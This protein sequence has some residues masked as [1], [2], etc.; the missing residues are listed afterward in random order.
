MLKFGLINFLE[1]PTGKSERQIT[2]EQKFILVSAEE[3]GFDAIWQVEHHFSEYGHCVSVAVMLATLASA[4]RRVRLGSGVIALP[5]HHPIRVAEEFALIDLLSDGRLDFGIG[6][7]FQPEEFRGYGIDQT[8]SRELFTEALQ[9]ILQAWTSKRVSFTGQHFQFTDV[10][11]KPKPLQKPHPPVWIAA[12]SPESFRFA[13]THGHNVIC[14]PIFGPLGD[15][16][17]PNLRDYRN[18]LNDHGHDPGSRQIAMLSMVYV[19]TNDEK[20]EADFCDAAVWSY[21]ALSKSANSS[22]GAVPVPSYE[23]YAALRKAGTAN[24]DTIR[25]SDLVIWGSPRRCIERI[26]EL[27]RRFGFTTLLCWTRVGALDDRKV[28]D[29]M[30]LMQEQ[31]MPHF[32]RHPAS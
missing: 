24:W 13:G 25:E 17:G 2:E 7:G 21:R 15:Y 31:V 28:R 5:F 20:A 22:Q 32:R 10:E 6:R 9:V 27:R 29:S 11:V 4:T 19:A 16:L 8:K 14:G 23:H 12:V 30:G 3:Y 1:D 26:E 18:S